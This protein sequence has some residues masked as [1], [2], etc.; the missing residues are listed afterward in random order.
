MINLKSGKIT[1]KLRLTLISLAVLMIVSGC[2]T[3]KKVPTNAGIKV[4]QP[5][6]FS[7][8]FQKAVFKTNMLVYG[9]ELSGLTM[10]KKTGQSFRV[11]FM[12]EIGLKYSDME[13]SEDNIVVH[14]MISILD[15]KPVVEMLENNYRL[16]FM[17][18]PKKTTEKY[19]SDSR[20]KGMIKEN[21]YKRQKSRYTYDANFG[22]VK[23]IFDK[24]RGRNLSV[25]MKINDHLAPETININQ[26]NL[27][28]RLERLD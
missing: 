9:N 16:L 2:R 7:I 12:S 20:T 4:S 8:D 25:F 14:H 18:F 10:I 11:V 3:A 28:L 23:T 19:F 22:M 27:N 1:L 24:N 17:I 15:R 21:R 6:V 13:F 5:W 26:T